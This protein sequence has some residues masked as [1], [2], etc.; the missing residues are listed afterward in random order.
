MYSFEN[1]FEN[2]KFLSEVS[3]FKFNLLATNSAN[4]VLVELKN[5][6]FMGRVLLRVFWMKVDMRSFYCYLLHNVLGD[7]YTP[8]D[9]DG[10]I[11]VLV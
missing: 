8:A 5:K 4:S 11:G 2:M 6:V 7:E 3:H 1:E 10:I 9:K